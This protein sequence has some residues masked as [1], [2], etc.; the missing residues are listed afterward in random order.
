VLELEKIT[1]HHWQIV[2]C[3]AVTGQNLL[4][5]RSRMAKL[6]YTLPKIEKLSSDRNIP[7]LLYSS[8]MKMGIDKNV[9]LHCIKK[10]L[11]YT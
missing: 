5:V 1:T 4:K 11:F 8:L 3:S 7:L 9:A 2:S 6:G 10:I